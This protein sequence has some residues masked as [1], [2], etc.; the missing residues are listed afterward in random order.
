MTERGQKKK[1]FQFV[2]K[3]LSFSPLSILFGV[4][5]EICLAIQKKNSYNITKE[6]QHKIGDK[7]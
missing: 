5:F 2:S 3:I 7:T 4:F 1:N 6:N